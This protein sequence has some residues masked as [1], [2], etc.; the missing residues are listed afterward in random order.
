[1]GRVTIN[2][3]V[4]QFSCKQTIPKELW[5]AKGNKAKGKSMEARETNLALDNIKAQ[6]QE[7]TDGRQ[8]KQIQEIR[9]AYEQQHRK[10]SEFV[11]FVKRY[12][13]YVEK[14]IPTIKFLRETLNFGD[15]VIRK[16]CTFKDVSIKGE[17]YSC[18]FNQHFRTDKTIC[19]LKEDK[20]GNFNLNIDGVSHVSWFRKKKDEWR[21]AMGT[22]KPRQMHNRGMKL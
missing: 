15:A 11:D 20:D 18:E 14:L 9:N 19:S 7:R 12:F 17:L 21:E 3:S 22:L 10:L 1:M 6:S 16:L 2:G 4:A 8:A 13:P 5:D